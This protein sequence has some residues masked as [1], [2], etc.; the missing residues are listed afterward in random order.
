[1]GLALPAFPKLVVLT[2]AGN[3]S[4]QSSRGE[5]LTSNRRLLSLP[6]ASLSASLRR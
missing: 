6:S 5:M 3:R 2:L 1:M 4:E